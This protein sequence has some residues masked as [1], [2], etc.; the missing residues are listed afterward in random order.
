MHREVVCKSKVSVGILTICDTLLTFLFLFI[1]NKFSISG[2]HLQFE[3]HS[4]RHG[5]RDYW[6]EWKEEIFRF[7]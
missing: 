4:S 3:N 1:K 6:S 5:R 7:D 2:F